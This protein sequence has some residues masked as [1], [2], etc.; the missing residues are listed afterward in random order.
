[1][2]DDRLAAELQEIRERAQWTS[3]AKG[4][5][6]PGATALGSARDVPR[7]LA[8]VE[9]VLALADGAYVMLSNR[10]GGSPEPVA[11][12]LDPAAVREAI[13]EELHR[14]PTEEGATDGRSS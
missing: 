4:I 13:A 2:T 8:A 11:W 9:R 7:L 1:M 10:Q 14:D 5:A 6:K 12:D 3:S